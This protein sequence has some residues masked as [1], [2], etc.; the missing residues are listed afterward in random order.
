MKIFAVV[1]L[2]VLSPL[3]AVVSK[4]DDSYAE[5]DRE[6]IQLLGLTEK[7]GKCYAR[8]MQQQRL[9]FLALEAGQWNKELALYR[10]TFGLLKPVLTPRQHAR[11]V[12]I[13]NSVIEFREDDFYVVSEY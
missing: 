5:V 3:F 4:A 9:Q 13:I 8:I 7:Q 12:G 2:I 1:L 10:E 11:F 6:M